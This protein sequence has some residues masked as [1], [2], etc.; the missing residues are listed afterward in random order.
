MNAFERV[1][2]RATAPNVSALIDAVEKQREGANPARR[3]QYDSLLTTLENSGMA[4]KVD[5]LEG[6]LKTDASFRGNLYR[7][8]LH[9]PAALE[10]IAPQAL[11]NPGN[12]KE[13][14][15]TAARPPRPVVAE[16]HTEAR[17]AAPAHAASKPPRPHVE[18]QAGARPAPVEVAA[19]TDAP[20]TG[21][22]S[23]PPVVTQTAEEQSFGDKFKRLQGIEGYAG[24]VERIQANPRLQDMFGTMVNGG[25]DDPAAAEK[26]ID[27]ILERAESNPKIF[28]ELSRTIDEKPGVVSSIAENMANNPQ[29]GLMALG[30]YSQFQQGGGLGQM[31]RLFGPGAL[32]GMI[33]G[34]M[35]MIGQFFG[36]SG[37]LMAMGNNGGDLLAQFGKIVGGLP[38]TV[39][40][41]AMT[42]E[43]GSPARPGTETPV[44]L[45]Q[46]REEQLRRDGQLQRPGMAA[47]AG[48]QPSGAG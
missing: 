3:A 42:G 2:L 13:L 14:V 21:E 12:M 7:L 20:T 17:P 6:M 40:I 15:A 48:P 35:N 25:G 30:M 19:A 28:V 4:S 32:D 8:A 34:L 10:R 36:G 26:M 18:S 29:A 24:L 23:A 37:G 5:R 31:E 39:K 33:A 43:A 22:E 46:Q 11:Q 38:E 44:Q 1:A 41:D 47:P 27:G 16:A 9:N 45:A